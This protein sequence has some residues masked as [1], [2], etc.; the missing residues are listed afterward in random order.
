M[1][2]PIF[3]ENCGHKV[4]FDGHS[5]SREGTCKA[6]GL[7]LGRSVP[8]AAAMEGPLL[9][10]PID[11][12][13]PSGRHGHLLD[14][15]SPLIVRPATDDPHAETYAVSRPNAPVSPSGNT[16]SIGDTGPRRHSSAGPPPFW[17]NAP[18]LLA[19]SLARRLRT[20]RDAIYL[21]SV[22]ALVLALVGFLFKFKGLL[23]V[24]VVVAIAANVGILVVGLTYL[25]MLPFK[26]G[27]RY[28]L[29]NLL[30][31]L[32]AVYYWYTRWPRMKP[33][34]GKTFGAFLPIVLATVAFFAYEDGSKVIDFGK[35][36][37]PILEGKIEQGVNKLDLGP[38]KGIEGRVE[39]AVDSGQDKSQGKSP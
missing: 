39:G 1:S 29:A 6:C 33:A 21:V 3:C 10:R 15:H 35:K 28:G 25:V 2:V 7:L 11:G 8:S 34:I 13:D 31:P 27:L 9:L 18:S 24:G 26:E 22:A 14:P 12:P 37:L 38:V 20:V 4:E 36:E 23:H 30:I 17:V 5:A 19:R 32:Y 16:Y